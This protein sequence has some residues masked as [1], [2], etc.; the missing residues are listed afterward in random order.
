LA[1][2]H[3]VSQVSATTAFGERWIEQLLARYNDW[4]KCF[5]D[6]LWR[7]P[8]SQALAIGARAHRQVTTGGAY[9]GSLREL[10]MNAVATDL[11]FLELT[12]LVAVS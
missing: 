10:K 2:G 8:G 3:T 5:V 9:F 11:H 6:R 12:E 4:R 7:R 1:R